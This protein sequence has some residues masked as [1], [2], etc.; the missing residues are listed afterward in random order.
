MLFRSV[1][2]MVNFIA[3]ADGKND[4]FDISE[5][6]GVPVR[7]ILPIADKLKNVGLLKAVD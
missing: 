5:I 6:I 3:Y 7:E 2:T 4:L 1:T